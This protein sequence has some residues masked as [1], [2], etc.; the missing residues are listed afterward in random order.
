ML[1]IAILGLGVFLFF[2][3]YCPPRYHTLRFSDQ[4]HAAHIHAP[5]KYAPHLMG[6]MHFYYGTL[7]SHTRHSDGLL[8]PE[9]ALWWARYV[10]GYDFYALTDHGRYITPAEWEHAAHLV[11]AVT[12]PGKFVALRGFEWGLNYSDVNHAGH[13]NV[14]NTNAYVTVDTVPNVQDLYAWVMA[15]NGLAHFNHPKRPIP[16]DATVVADAAAKIFGIETG[17]KRHGNRSARYSP[18]YQQALDAGWRVAPVYG[19]D[20]HLTPIYPYRTVI[21]AQELIPDSLLE[22]FQ[23]RRVYST[24]DPTL[25]VVFKLGK[26]WMGSV[27]SSNAESIVLTIFLESERTID[28]VEIFTCNAVCAQKKVV[29][30]RSVHWEPVV[31]VKE[32]TFFYLKITT[33]PKWLGT[34]RSIAVSAPIWVQRTW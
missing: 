34:R 17:N 9:Q 20:N 8:R 14:Y 7:H 32:D 24:D 31:T 30:A 23:A 1:L 33:R 25:R 10:A 29:N 3:W 26:H 27:V 21:I 13:V 4:E 12:E 28:K 5:H 19:Q 11:D 16:Y 18:Y 15:H 22:A 2:R 6:S